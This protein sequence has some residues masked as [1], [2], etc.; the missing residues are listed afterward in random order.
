MKITTI[1]RRNFDGAYFTFGFNPSFDETYILKANAD[2]IKD[3]NVVEENE[4]F[5]LRVQNHLMRFRKDG[6]SLPYNNIPIEEGRR[7]WI[8]LVHSGFSEI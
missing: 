2:N 5:L 4:H 1:Y 8:E 7:M 3:I 6:T